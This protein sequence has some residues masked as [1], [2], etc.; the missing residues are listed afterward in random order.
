MIAP[1]ARWSFCTLLIAYTLSLWATG[2][3]PP[4][5]EPAKPA[6]AAEVSSPDADS[7]KTGASP[8][9]GWRAGVAVTKITPDTLMWM[10]GYAA[11]KKPAEGTLQDLYAKALALEDENGQRAVIVTLDL[12][13]VLTSIREAV[14]K[15]VEEQYKL[16]PA[17]LLLNASHTHCG[18]EYR[19]RAGREEEAGN[20]HQFLQTALVKLVGEAL[21]D[22]QPARLSYGH[23]RAGFA[24]NRRRNYALPEDDV[25]ARKA[26]NPDG[27]VDHDVPVLCVSD[28]EGNQRVVLF[29]YACHNTT[30]QFFQF[31][32]DYAGF[33]QEHL[34]A[35]HPGMTAMFVMGCGA[36][37]N[38]YPRSTVEL[39][40]KHGR[41]LATAVEAALFA[42]P[43]PLHGSIRCALEYVDL[44]WADEAK[45]ARR[46]PVQVIR[47]GDDVTLVALASEVVVDYSLRLKRELGHP[48]AVVWVAG[49][50]NGY[51]GYIPSERVLAE[52]G[53]EAPA[54][55]TGIE[56]TIIGK[57]VQLC[58]EMESMS[59]AVR[60]VMFG[61][62]ITNG[63]GVTEAETFREVARTEL[64]KRLG[65][66]V[67][68]ANAGVNG[69][70]V[71]L[72]SKRLEKDVL[73][74][75][76]ALVTIMFGGNEAG[77]YRPETNGF[78]ETP[79]VARD[80]FK[81][82]LGAIVDR[83]RAARITV[84][85]MT[86]PPMTERYWGAD[87]E[88]Y[89]KH[90]INFLVADYAQAMRDVAAEKQVELI[91]VYDAFQQDDNKL[92]YFPDGLHPNARGHQVIADLL[93]PRLAQMVGQQE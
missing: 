38:P 24:M 74:R 31:C 25:N 6:P 68:V 39:A 83:L 50:S 62:S 16:P 1:L 92:D 87:L 56:E 93:V 77:F 52:G 34:Q 21:A 65:R 54:Y 5:P 55:A 19:E 64:T 66:P 18:P 37:Q 23:A 58:R 7:K 73:D 45:E 79:R 61:D 14:E 2:Q 69:D 82:A 49:Y 57:A 84:V 22:L 29:G 85:L 90:G 70:V 47:L 8:L 44:P 75:K 78:A 40:E 43:R 67:E 42:H 41:S 71:T 91:D 12:I 72:A 51:F 59:E 89:Q 10:A 32:G 63:A 33:A 3:T 17:C 20:Y 80:E 11:R 36:D 30:L 35:D 81:A 9:L 88:P 86:C 76:P 15:E 27:P 60:I 28:A 26:P 53:Y 46:Y 13:G 4:K 48:P